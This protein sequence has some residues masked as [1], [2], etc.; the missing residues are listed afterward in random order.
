MAHSKRRRTEHKKA[1][2]K[3]TQL[4]RAGKKEIQ[5]KKIKELWN[6]NK[7]YQKEQQERLE[8]LKGHSGYEKNIQEGITDK[9]KSKINRKKIA[10]ARFIRKKTEKKQKK[11]KK[12]QEKDESRRLFYI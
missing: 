4:L 11:N 3:T 12:H 2:N 8:K 1:K 9:E 6:K 10:R 5:R 7:E